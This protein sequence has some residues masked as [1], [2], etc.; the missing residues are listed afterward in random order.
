MPGTV[1][2]PFY[3]DADDVGLEEFLILGVFVAGKNAPVQQRK[4]D[5][6]LTDLYGMGGRRS[7]FGIMRQL[8]ADGIDALLR[9]HKVGQYKRVTAALHF[10]AV[11]DFDLRTCSRDDLILTPGVSYKTASFFLLFTRPG[12]QVA[13][14]DTHILKWMGMHHTDIPDSS[15]SGKKYLELE[16]RWIANAKSIGRHDLAQFD[17]EL[18]KQYSK[19]G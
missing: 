4:R 13:C 16:E 2:D 1:D 11:S 8:G 17:F 14:L 19:H 10:L 5:E 15:P 18:W 9:L 7:P 3:F 12:A 6:Y